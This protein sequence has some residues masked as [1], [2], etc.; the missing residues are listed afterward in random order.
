MPV[1]YKTIQSTKE[2]KDGARLFHPRVVHTATIGT[3][4]L[5]KEIAEYSSL[6]TGDVKNTIDNM[7]T[8]MTKHLHS[9]ES[10]TVD[11]LGTFGIIMRS[12]GKGAATSDEVKAAQ[13]LLLVRFTPSFTKNQDHT[14]ATRALITGVKCVPYNKDAAASGGGSGGNEGGGGNDGDQGENPLG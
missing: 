4:Q 11:G 1:L 2:N 10:V 6:S 9:S 3:A 13:A 8:V 12:K 7:V 5:A 14:V